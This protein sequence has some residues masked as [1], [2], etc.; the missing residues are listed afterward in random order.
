MAQPKTTHLGPNL[1]TRC[2]NMGPNWAQDGPEMGPRANAAL[3]SPVGR[4][5]AP[6][7]CKMSFKILR[8]PA[9]QLPVI[10]GGLAAWGVAC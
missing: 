6:Q 1:A 5:M 7:T 10:K 9:T 3:G 2:P 4:D 8:Y